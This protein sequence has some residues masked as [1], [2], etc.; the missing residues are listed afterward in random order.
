[1]GVVT[2]RNRSPS[3]M[4]KRAIEVIVRVALEVSLGP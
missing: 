1:M 3:P 2:L 4:A